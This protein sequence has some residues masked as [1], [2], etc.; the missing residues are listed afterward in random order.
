MKADDEVMEDTEDMAEKE[1]C[2]SARDAGRAL[3][4][5]ERPPRPNVSAVLVRVGARSGRGEVTA[6]LWVPEGK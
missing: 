1:D 2:E 4:P 5:G 3:G 6:G